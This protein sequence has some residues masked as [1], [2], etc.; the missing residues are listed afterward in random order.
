MRPDKI[1]IKATSITNLSDARYFASY[2]AALLGF[3]FDPKSPDFVNPFK[4]QEIAGWVEGPLL[5]GEFNY[6]KPDAIIETIRALNLHFAQVNIKS[7]TKEHGSIDMVPLIFEADI[8]NTADFEAIELLLEKIYREKD[9]ILLN[10]DMLTSI[11]IYQT[12]RIIL[13]KI[14]AK[15]PVVLQFNFTSENIEMLLDI[16]QPAGISLKGSS[17]AKQGSKPFDELDAIME[18]LERKM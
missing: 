14:C 18:S 15:Y 5:V 9:Y 8:D 12:H 2:N 6:L 16:F 1:F 10:I 4:M 11:D 13:Q 3:C 7:L 17:E